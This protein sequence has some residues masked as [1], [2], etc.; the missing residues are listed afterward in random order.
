M[1]K[2]FISR[3]LNP[4]SIFLQKLK[5]ADF[6]VIGE[7][8]VQFSPVPFTNFPETDWIFF[9]SKKAVRFFFENIQSTGLQIH[10]KLATLGEGTAAA[11]ENY[12][13]RPNFTG[14][15]QP[16]ATAKEFLKVA[17]NQEILFPRAQN[18]RQSI[19]E[20]LKGKIEVLDIVVYQNIPRNDFQIPECNWLVFTS[21][22]NA[23]AY[24]Q[25]Y[26]VKAGQKIIAIGETTEGALRTI[27]LEKIYIS[28]SPSEEAL[29][30]AI[31]QHSPM[32]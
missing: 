23:E 1:S 29:A 32:Q 6:E 26:S 25:R 14:N 30:N 19:Q 9:Y 8:L 31:L 21:P 11:L 27:G 7:S 17:E 16:E 22:L 5:V 18:S 4:D 13:F 15:G 3:S 28:E 2:V 20:L 12:G 10:A 24:F